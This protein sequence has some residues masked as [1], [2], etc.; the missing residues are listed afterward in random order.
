M[1][2]RRDALPGVAAAGL[3]NRLPVRDLGYQTTMSIEGRPDLDGARKPTSLYRLA[4]PAFFKTM[5]MRI[6]AVFASIV[7][8]MRAGRTSPAEALRATT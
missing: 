5:G 6:V 2:M 7:P 4:T 8:A 1:P 3:T